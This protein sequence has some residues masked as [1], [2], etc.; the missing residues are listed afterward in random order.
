MENKVKRGETGGTERRRR[1]SG[2]REEKKQRRQGEKKQEKLGPLCSWKESREEVTLAPSLAS[3]LSS[4]GRLS[5][6][7]THLGQADR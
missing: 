1:I 3:H 4:P 2:D 7:V 5:C 6:W